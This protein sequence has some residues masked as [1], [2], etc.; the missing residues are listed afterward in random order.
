MFRT[1]DCLYCSLYL[2]WRCSSLYD[3]WQNFPQLS[4]STTTFKWLTIP[5]LW[6]HTTLLIQWWKVMAEHCVCQ[7]AV[8]PRVKHLNKYTGVSKVCWDCWFSFVMFLQMSIVNFV[9][10][11]RIWEGNKEDWTVSTV[12]DIHWHMLSK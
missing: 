9:A 12:C 4:F 6:E 2:Q 1:N 11:A 8:S 7:A 5:R 3:F 10:R